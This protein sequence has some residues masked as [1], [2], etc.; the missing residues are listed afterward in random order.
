MESFKV[1][2]YSATLCLLKTIFMKIEAAVKIYKL[3]GYFWLPLSKLYM[4]RDKNC[5]EIVNARLL[6]AWPTSRIWG[7][8]SSFC[9]CMHV[10][11]C[12]FEQC[13]SYRTFLSENKSPVLPL[14]NIYLLLIIRKLTEHSS[15]DYLQVVLFVLFQN[16]QKVCALNFSAASRFS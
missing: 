11:L 12:V 7:F 13:V 4:Q 3:Y 6:F 10:C 8:F 9:K 16:S 2:N 5:Q 1:A 14:K 15:N